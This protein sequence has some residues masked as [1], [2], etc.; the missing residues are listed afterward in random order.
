MKYKINGQVF[1]TTFV[2]KKFPR[3]GKNIT[4]SHEKFQTNWNIHSLA[5]HGLENLIEP[6]KFLEKYGKK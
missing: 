2:I 3:N 4:D 6:L 5:N 1:E